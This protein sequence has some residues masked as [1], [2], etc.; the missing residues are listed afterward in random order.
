MQSEEQKF[1]EAIYDKMYQKLLT[2]AIQHMP[3]ISLAEEAVQETFRIACEKVGELMAHPNPGGWLTQTLK[4]VLR[5]MLRRQRTGESLV[6]EYLAVYGP[7]AAST[8]DKHPLD[9]SF[10]GVAHTEDFK[11]VKAMAID[12]RSHLELAKELGISVDA[13]KKRMQRAK[14]KLMKKLR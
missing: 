4:N 6:Q 5:N 2:Y 3:T 10:H 12:G 11:L 1:I 13:C 14:E 7:Q 8:S 9:V